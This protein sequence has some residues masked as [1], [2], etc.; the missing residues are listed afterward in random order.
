[1]KQRLIVGTLASLAAMLLVFGRTQALA[2][3]AFQPVQLPGVDRPSSTEPQDERR[4]GL[5]WPAGAP[6]RLLE[7][8]YVYSNRTPVTVGAES[9][10]DRRQRDRQ[11]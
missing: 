10:I 8:F 6:G 5:S 4:A 2:A 11:S 3:T 9:K 7:V 1:M